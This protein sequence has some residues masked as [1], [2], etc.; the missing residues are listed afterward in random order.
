MGRRI[1]VALL[2]MLA[3]TSP[4][5]VA[6]QDARALLEQAAEAMG[7]LERLRSLDNVTYTGFGQRAYYQGGG[8]ITGDPQ[9]PMKWQNVTDVQRTLHLKT[10]VADYQERW[11]QEFPFAGTFGLDYQRRTSTQSGEQLLDHPL[12]ALLA[13]LADDT[14]LG[15]VTWED[16]L[17]VI[18]FTPANHSGPAWIALDPASH[19]PRFSRWTSPHANLGDLTTTAWFSGYLPFAGVQLPMGLRQELDWRGVT[20]LMLQID[21]YRMNVPASQLPRVASVTI[22]PP[23][24]PQAQ[25]TSLAPG[26]WDVR[27][28]GAGAAV[29]EFANRLVMF[30]AYGG[31]AQTLLRIDAANRLVPGKQ[32]EAV[33]VSH[34][35]FDHTGGL[36]AALS[37]GLEVISH[38]GNESILRE[39]AERPATRFPD[40]LARN[41][42]P[43]RFTP[44]DERLVLEDA[45]RRLEIYRVIEHSHMP[46]GV[47]AYLPAERIMLEGDLGDE[48]W[49]YH[50]WGSGYAANI[51][52]YGI[53]P[54]T[55]VPV[56]GSGA[57]PMATVLANTARQVAAAQELCRTLAEGGRFQQGCPVQY[58]AEGALALEPR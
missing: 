4:V 29:V 37:R 56:H 58:D 18:A 53:A 17:T 16:G 22:A 57:I 25:V 2:A 21:S 51:A 15:P 20:N 24:P 12:P 47:F 38:R 7:G 27:V 32:V 31:E 6:A 40:A 35:H 45:T 26:V 11:G 55:N 5:R 8:N 36:R 44:V 41:P 30:E 54:E 19:L 52:H 13:A 42:R 43:F 50:F 28:N 46:N 14:E 39:L 1:I 3:F 10:G 33:I 23:P 48:A 34:H 9:A 49:N